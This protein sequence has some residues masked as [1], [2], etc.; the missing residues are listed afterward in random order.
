MRTAPSLF[1]SS[2]WAGR[3]VGLLGGSFNPAH[4]GHRHISLMALKHLGLDAVWWM[5][6]PQNPLKSTRDMAPLPARLASAQHAARHPQIVATDIETQ[7]GTQYTA[8]TLKKLRLYFARTRFIWLMGTDNLLQIH[9]WQNWHDIF[10]KHAVCVLDRPPRGNSLKSCPALE[11]YR[12]R[13]LPENAAP[14]LKHKNLPAW[15]ILHIPLNALSSTAIRAA[16]K[17]SKI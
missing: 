1:N 2:L 12:H 6:S 14:L 7:M 13:L 16:Q 17:G 15:T 3:S 5:V 10:E 9:R 4:D 8:D 11:R